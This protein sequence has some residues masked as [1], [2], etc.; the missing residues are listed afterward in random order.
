MPH[1]IVL[2]E[3]EPGPGI[4]LWQI[5][6]DVTLWA[7]LSPEQRGP[8]LFNDGAGQV[9]D[10][11]PELE[12]DL[13]NLCTFVRQAHGDAGGVIGYTCYRVARWAEERGSTG[14]ALEFMQAAA[15]ADRGTATYAY[16]VAKLARRLGD[17]AGASVWFSRAAVLARRA[18]DWETLARSYGGLGN[19]FRQ[20]G[21]IPAAV[22]QHVRSLRVARRYGLRDLQADAL[23]DL[24]VLRYEGGDP[25]AG[26]EL[27]RRAL[28][29]YGRGHARIPQLAHD[30]A[31]CWMDYE[32]RFADGLSVLRLLLGHAWRPADGLQLMA[33]LARAAA[34][35]GDRDGFE[36]ACTDIHARMTGAADQEC[37]AAALVD[38]ARGAALLGETERAV[39]I[40]A[41]AL[42]LARERREGRVAVEAEAILAEIRAEGA[43]P[44]TSRMPIGPENGEQAP[45]AAAFTVALRQSGRTRD[46]VAHALGAVID[47]P[48]DPGLAYNL[49]RL[50]R[51]RA[52]YM[53]AVPW[54]ERAIELAERAGNQEMCVRARGG[55]ANLL[56]QRGD[57]TAA[58]TVHEQALEV[59]RR[60]GV[61][62]LEGEAL[63]DLCVLRFEMG[64][65]EAGFACARE[66][67]RAYGPGHPRVPKLAHDVAVYLLEAR[68]DHVNALTIFRELAF[69]TFRDADLLLLHGNL[70]RAAAGAGEI[71]VFEKAWDDARIV[72]RR[73]GRD[74]EN[75]AAALIALAHA[76]LISGRTE[77]A[78][79]AV[80]HAHEIASARQEARLLHLAV[81][82][83]ETVA[84]AKRTRVRI[85][86]FPEPDHDV[87]EAAS[88]AREIRGA[89]LRCARPHGEGTRTP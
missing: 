78:E 59:A 56:R 70:A 17:A 89:V 43:A 26:A 36:S 39:H 47:N 87:K 41:Q 5:L 48:S 71:P 60:S 53:R 38:L 86:P 3:H 21:N 12:I 66:A 45:L 58:V 85:R 54:F 68:G 51:N 61:R 42:A 37:H 11:I 32:G 29:A 84:R 79:R 35:V 20:R 69:C 10:A 52:E 1:A 81:E 40:A 9:R 13:G 76:A 44:A 18:G 30:V 34:G 73:M 55:L 2:D 49:A 72:L 7:S 83:R 88:L 75:H 46:E 57:P 64:D 31:V 25:A 77:W 24:C 19:L 62:E 4:V 80:E 28:R 8:E 27:A 50:L 14:T 23:N 74:R 63:F 65:G 16:E 22:E 82:L 33:S 15:L 67:V 6:R